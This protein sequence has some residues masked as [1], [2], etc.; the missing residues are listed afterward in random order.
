MT[1][2][3]ILYVQMMEKAGEIT[4]EV[5]KCLSFGTS[6]T[7][8]AKEGSNESRLMLEIIDLLAII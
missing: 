8:P 7:F 2:K 6:Q 4:Q 5:S 3:E 1:R